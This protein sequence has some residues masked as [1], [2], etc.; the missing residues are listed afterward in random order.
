MKTTAVRLYGKGDLRIEAFELPEIAEDELLVKMIVDSVCMSTHKEAL[1]ASDHKRVPNNIAEK[2]IIVGHE[3]CAEVVEVGKKRINDFNTGDRLIVQAA[4]TETLDAPGYS[5]ENFGGNSTHSII[6]ANVIDGGYAIPYGADAC[7]YGALAEPLSCVIGATHATYHTIPGEYT[8]IMEPKKDGTMA[9]LASVGPMG[10]AF[11][12]YIIHR[13]HSPRLLVV[14]DIDD[15]RLQRAAQLITP[16]DARSNGVELHYVNTKDLPDSVASLREYTGGDGFDDVFVYAPVKNVIEQADGILGVDGCMN[17]FAG[18][19][20]EDFTA[21]INFYNVHYNF[22][23]I[24]GTTGG[25]TNDMKEALDLATR[26]I[27]NPSIL[28]THIGGL[29]SAIDTIMNLPSIPGGKKLVYNE[30]SMP[31]TAISDFE[32]LG[33]DSEFFA[34]LAKMCEKHGGLWNAEAEKHLLANGKRL[35][36]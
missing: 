28:V 3:F 26:G 31:M 4:M 16:E 22:T 23:H 19:Q 10:M 1:R 11:L 13:E 27:I 6:P 29:D 20:D 35:E 34:T 8:H 33:K 7:Y 5:F 17:F 21:T 32:E 25:N 24:M 9:A 2:P 14:T 18:P 30:I 12:D 15:T 36:Y